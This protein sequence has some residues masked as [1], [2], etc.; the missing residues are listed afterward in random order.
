MSKI[1][2]SLI[3]GL[4]FI[5]VISSAIVL[6][7]FGIKTAKAQV[8]LKEEITFMESYAVGQTLNIPDAT[9]TVNGNEC[10]TYKVVYYPN[11][12]VYKTNSAVLKDNGVY[13]IE[14]RAEYQNK[15]YTKSFTFNAEQRL[16]ST[17]NTRSTAEYGVDLNVENYPDDLRSGIAGINVSILKGDTFNYNQVVDLSDNNS[18]TP[19]MEIMFNPSL[20]PKSIDMEY[21]YVTLTDAYNAD[22]AVTIRIY[23]MNYSISDWLNP[24]YSYRHDAKARVFVAASATG[25]GMK[26]VSGSYVS[27]GQDEGGC[28]IKTNNWLMKVD[29]S[30]PYEEQELTFGKD[31]SVALYFDYATNAIYVSGSIDKMP[32][33][34]VDL[35]EM[36]YQDAKFNGFTTGEVFVS[37]YGGRYIQPKMNMVVTYLDG[38]TLDAEFSDASKVI[39]D[40]DKEVYGDDNIVAGVG[41]PFKIFNAKAIDMYHKDSEIPVSARVYL[42]NSQ[43]QS[44]YDLPIIDGC[45]TPNEVG[46]YT[47]EYSAKG[48]NGQVFNSYVSLM[49]KNVS[50]QLELTTSAQENG[51]AGVKI[52]V[53]DVQVSNG[54]GKTDIEYQVKDAKGNVVEVVDGRFL[55]TATG[56]YTVKVTAT[57]YIGRS[58]SQTK[59]VTVAT[60]GVELLQSPSINDI[61]F[62]NKTYTLPS[63]DAFDYNANK[64]ANVSVFVDDTLTTDNKIKFNKAGSSVVKYMSGEVELFTKT[65]TVIDAF[66][67]DPDYGYQYSYAK[68]FTSDAFDIT[69]QEDM[70]KF[71]AKNA[72]DKASVSFAN[73]LAGD[74]FNLIFAFFNQASIKGVEKISVYLIDSENPEEQLKVSFLANSTGSYPLYL[75][76]NIYPYQNCKL[77]PTTENVYKLG[78]TY[79]NNLNTLTI[80]DCFTRDLSL[81]GYGDEFNGLSSN[82]LKLKIEFE[83]VSENFEFGVYSL[84]GQAVS[85]DKFDFVAPQILIDGDY[86]SFVNN[87]DTLDI[88]SAIGLDVVSGLGKANVQVIAPSGMNVTAIDG[89]ELN[90]TNAV[91]HKIKVEEY[92]IYTIIYSAEDDSGVSTTK[93]IS[94]VCI[95]REAPKFEVTFDVETAKLNDVITIPNGTVTDNA[96]NENAGLYCI[97]IN[98]MGYKV[99]YNQGDEVKLEKVG[100]YIFR[101]YAVDISGNTSSLDYTVVV[102]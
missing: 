40:V 67:D 6:S 10:E 27:A 1:K 63:V 29:G 5:V 22:N 74:N 83:G 99:T 53:F 56:A 42:A 38:Q 12:K 86:T 24:D 20:G 97:V 28:S 73:V 64:S 18:I 34:V 31:S 96:G 84:C 85:S 14:Y 16:F 71:T 81:L 102:K 93:F 54:C 13:K 80:D 19:F 62:T 17:T 48:F 9:I 43:G 11:G 33:L 3:M 39:F 44:K 89:T 77:Y 65:V 7:I 68:F 41:K 26:S 76:D 100:K 78:I 2:K 87:G 8:S 52:P 101:F 45:F 70:L 98:P 46:N 57:D 59:T 30:K 90:G 92:G 75:N 69:E 15:L 82:L 25:Q 35:D 4:A 51:K 32:T 36:T 47:I 61:Y 58:G 37:M 66:Y 50:D 49:A 79:K 60:G 72:V 23:N 21:L 95:D 55:P 88:Y 94:T 91:G